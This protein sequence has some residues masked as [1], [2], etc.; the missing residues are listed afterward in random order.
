MLK[1]KNFYN[2]SMIED[3]WKEIYNHNITRSPFQSFEY[4]KHWYK[5]FAE[6]HDLCIYRI[7]QNQRTIGFLPLK[8]K[9]KYNCRIFT[10][11]TNDH[12]LHSEPLIRDQYENI[13]KQL[14]LELLWLE[15]KNW[16]LLKISFGYSF[17]RVPCLIKNLQQ[18]RYNLK[19]NIT[20]Q[21]T[22]TIDLNNDFQKYEQGLSQ[23]LRKTIKRCRNRMRK[24]GKI[25]FKYFRDE[26]AKNHWTSFL[27]IEDSGWKGL[28]GT[29]ILKLDST[30][31]AYYSGL[32]D[33]LA[34]KKNLWLFF[35]IVND[36]P[37]A[38]EFGYT[39]G[40]VYHSAKSAYDEYYKDLSPSN[41]LLLEVIE[42]FF[43]N[44]MKLSKIHLFPWQGNYKKRFINE[45]AKCFE[46]KIFSNSL[47]GKIIYSLDKVKGS[48][49][50]KY[51]FI[52]GKF[53][54]KEKV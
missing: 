46:T 29:S 48:A 27:K 25:E 11:L 19:T 18:C 15:K 22:F 36:T 38:S 51:K 13:F 14:L 33:I 3:E 9:R 49:K 12:C 41:M 32:I 26:H 39:F 10:S 5:C 21:D 47:R 52:T 4:I 44:T 23:N 35:L 28:A 6:P 7:T 45:K 2:L 31:K 30:Y 24:I 20:E 54:H 53:Q 34:K 50:N 16:D 43:K 17:E 42:F 40:G 8:P 1:I 37:I